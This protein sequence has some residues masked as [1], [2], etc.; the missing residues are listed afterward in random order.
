MVVVGWHTSPR[1]SWWLP[2]RHG[3]ETVGH[4]AGVVTLRL[5]TSAVA[6]LLLGACSFSGVAFKVD[7]RLDITTPR[8]REIVT[9][10]LTVDWDI[11]GFTVTGPTS[12]DADDAGYFGVFVDG[13]PQPPG[14]PLSYFARDDDTCR[15]EDGCPDEAYLAQRGIHATAETQFT[16]DLLP[17]PSDDSKRE[18]HE[19]T[20]VL[21]DGQGD[22][23]GESAWAV[24]F[25]VER[26]QG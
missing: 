8:E 2:T 9:L 1:A 7:E 18:F 22:R 13:R 12:S 25:E 24:E 10:P 23:I 26:N 6:V 16:I 11:E 3:R 14:E 15:A 21:L 20:V 4:H 17:R 5:L 19:V